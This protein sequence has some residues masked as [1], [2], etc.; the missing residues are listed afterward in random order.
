MNKLDEEIKLNSNKFNILLSHTPN[1]LIKSK[2][3]INDYNFINDCDLILTG[4]NHAGLI[5]TF[6]QDIFNNHIGLFGPFNKLISKTAYG[7]WVNDNKTLLVSNGVTKLSN[8]S[9]AHIIRNFISN[10]LYSA[11]IDL[12]RI[13]K[14]NKN[15][16]KLIN[17]KK[18]R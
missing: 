8:S 14:D 13:K 18:Y 16:F 6:I 7:Y 12:I 10:N 1:P 5:P 9:K 4:H 2:K 15:S 3:I 17:R 11:E